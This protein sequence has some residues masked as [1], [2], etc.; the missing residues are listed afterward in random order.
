MSD[1]GGTGLRARKP[2]RA[3]DRATAPLAP[4]PSSAPLGLRNRSRSSSS[5]V[6]GASDTDGSLGGVPDECSASSGGISSVS[7]APSPA[8][9]RVDADGGRDPGGVDADGALLSPSARLTAATS[10]LPPPKIGYI[11]SGRRFPVPRTLGIFDALAF[12]R[13]WGPAELVVVSMLL[14]NCLSLVCLKSLP[15][16]FF[17]VLFAFWRLA[18]NVGLGVL[19]RSQSHSAVVTRWLAG[20]SPKATAAV[21]RAVTGS[22]GADFRW[23]KAP[24]ELN[25]WLVFR[26]GA[27]M[28]LANDGCTYVLL[29]AKCF[30][31]SRLPT[32]PV[33]MVAAAVG[34]GL[35]AFCYW[36]KASAHR[37]VG[38]FAW[39]WGD[40]FFLMDGELVFD[41]VFELFPHPMYTVGYAAYYGFAL[42]CRSY[43]LLLVSMVAH[44]LQLLFLVAI[45]EPHIQ[46][47]Y[48]SV[49]ADVA[50]PTATAATAPPSVT[51][52]AAAA[53][54][55]VSVSAAPGPPLAGSTPSSPRLSPSSSSSAAAAA[56]ASAAAATAY[57]VLG[58][59]QFE[60]LRQGDLVLGALLAHVVATAVWP[61]LSPTYYMAQLVAW[62]LAHWVILGVVLYRQSARA[63]WTRAAARRGESP[64]AAFAQWKRVYHT[65]TVVNRVV[66]LVAASHVAPG[67]VTA[68]LSSPA[69]AA[70]SAVGTGLGAIAFYA[71]RSATDAIGE[72]A[73]YYV[74]FFLPPTR[75]A[76]VYTGVFRYVN[77]PKAA[78]GCLGAYGLALTTGSWALGA[79]AAASQLAHVALVYTVEVPHMNRLYAGRRR[80]AAALERALRRHAARVAAAAD[81][82]PLVR[83][84]KVRVADGVAAQ[85]ARLA[86]EA[87][88]AV[89]AV[90]DMGR[91]L[92]ERREALRADIRALKHR[93][94]S[95]D[96]YLKARAVRD[97]ALQRLDG[98]EVVALLERVGLA[99][100]ALWVDSD[101]EEEGELR[102]SPSSGDTGAT[103]D[104][105]QG[106][107]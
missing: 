83:D 53:A 14:L 56:A 55:G 86:A 47:T 3:V 6:S 57:G 17:V 37:C 96:L 67:W 20:L 76:P 39:Y 69:A 45:E 4:E 24:V 104:A 58:L 79:V 84:V 81:E 35:V 41:G 65:S 51:A 97:G 21:K 33:A 29:V 106:A 54:T 11:S 60:P 1:L 30:S 44:A 90:G 73:A 36:A 94:R 91:A 61:G 15:T 66:F 40:F 27:M 93:L 16:G 95:H 52:S 103:V 105:V 72:D 71:T 8:S 74:D 102:R 59:D 26:A 68:A 7:A 12:P 101:S 43:T 75:T 5:S 100:P 10:A 25:A 85:G 38:D 88:G 32:G 31:E 70:R 107:R 13:N 2:G 82:V 48:G 63:T 46:R 62:R 80:H 19:L 89:G 23:S 49:A 34:A 28:V 99:N 98:D 42:I 22:M 64:A 9:H 87:K 18:Y 92:A 78:L 50:A 77:H